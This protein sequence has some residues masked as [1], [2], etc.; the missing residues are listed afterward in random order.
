VTSA[1]TI[2]DQWAEVYDTRPNPL[3]SLEQ[4]ILP[5]L[6]PPIA[7]R[8]VLDVGCGTGRWLQLLS[9][10]SPNSLTGIDPSP[11][12]LAHARTR[13]A[14][15]VTLHQSDATQLPRPDRSTDLIL[16]S[17]VLS[18]LP[19][20]P[21]FAAECA[22]ILRPGGHLL[23][24]DMHPVTARERGW[25]RSFRTQGERIELPAHTHTLPDLLAAFTLYGF[26]CTTLLEPAFGEPEHAL[27]AQAGRTAD[28]LTSIPA[29]YLLKLHKPTED[30]HLAK[31]R[32]SE[33]P[34]RWNDQ[35]LSTCNGLLSLAPCGHSLDL[36]GYVLLP[37]LINAH[38]HLEF[39]LFPNL[40]RTPD[41]PPYRNSPEW[42]EEIHRTH[43][44]LI[45]KHRRVPL[46][47]RLSWGAIRNLLCGVTTVCHHNPL[48]PDLLDPAFPIRIVQEFGWSHSLTFAPDLDDRFHATP[49]HHPFLL[50]AAEGLDPASHAEFHTLHHRGLIDDRT[51]LIHGLALN[52]DDILLLNQAHASLIVCPTS[53]Q[54][55][56]GQTLP[57]HLMAAVERI[58]LGSDSPL[59]AAGDLLDEIALLRTLDS[60]DAANLYR[61]VTS[62][63][64]AI[65]RLP[66]GTGTLAPGLPADLIA[67][68]DHRRTPAE[69]LAHLTID[70]VE[71]VLVGGRVQ[72]A[73]DTLYDL[74]SRPFQSGLERLEI[75]GHPRWLRAPLET[76]FRTTKQGLD[77]D[78]LRLGNKEVRHRQSL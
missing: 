35:P 74:L 17:F 18:Y 56:F 6:L 73:S 33:S 36:S 61:L 28:D 53:N 44:A 21:C 55:L 1:A 39:A 13:L 75:E 60:L 20:L 62:A 9:P 78:T 19:D 31:T 42:A 7:N 30:L 14:P 59:T 29:I 12:M 46:A 70:Q 67:V 68:R 69:T 10:L 25:T 71:L 76:L 16:A 8:D 32:W 52:A 64:A 47:T 50:H 4:R 57:T 2:F 23:L 43:A 63:P 5:T 54:F 38:D 26:T 15:S 58:A 22:R 34:D 37:G 66:P 48:H 27:F 41:Q 51:V 11:A 40:G 49:S 24:S 65:L 77:T 72:L 3:L 45:Q